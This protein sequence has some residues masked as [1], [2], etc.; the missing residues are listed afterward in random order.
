MEEADNFIHTSY[1]VEL[2][3]YTPPELDL[4]SIT[5]TRQDIEENICYR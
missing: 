1:N 2:N 5:I 4:I 3:E